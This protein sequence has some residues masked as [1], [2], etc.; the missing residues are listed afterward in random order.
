MAEDSFGRE[1]GGEIREGRCRNRWK[2]E[3]KGE[4]RRKEGAGKEE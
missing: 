2:G 1:K 3:E 4:E